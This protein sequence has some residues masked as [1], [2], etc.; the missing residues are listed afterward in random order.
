[1]TDKFCHELVKERHKAMIVT[2]FYNV[3]YWGS[4]IVIRDVLA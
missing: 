1:M 4:Q 2:D 3:M